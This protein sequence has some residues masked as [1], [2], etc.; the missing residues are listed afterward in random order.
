MGCVQSQE[1]RRTAAMNKDI[2]AKLE[3][4]KAKAVK[5]IKMLLLGKYFLI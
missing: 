4:E 3:E 1:D 5:E 2:D